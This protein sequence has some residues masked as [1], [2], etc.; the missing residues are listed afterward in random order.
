MSQKIFSLSHS[1]YYDDYDPAN[2]YA[3]VLFRP[4]YPVQARELTTLQTTIQDQLSRLG[5]SLYKDGARVSRGA[6]TISKDATRMYLTGSTNSSY[7]TGNALSTA[8]YAPIASFVNKV[9]SSEDG[10]VKARLILQP[11]SVNTALYIGNIYIKY[12]T[13]K[14]FD[15]DGGYIYAFADDNP[16]LTSALFNTYSSTSECTIASI[17]EGTYFLKGIFASVSEQ[18]LVIDSAGTTPTGNIGLNVS[19]TI[20]TQ[21]DDD[22]LFDNARGTTNEGSPGAHRLKLTSTLTFRDVDAAADS[23]FYRLATITDGV[24]TDLAQAGDA[25]AGA[26]TDTLARRTYDES[27]HYA[28]KPFTHHISEA[29]SDGKIAINVGASKAYVKG[30]EINKIAT[31]EVTFD[32][33]LDES[34]NYNF[35]VPF[36]GTTAAEVSAFTGFTENEI[37]TFK[38]GSTEVGRARGYSYAAPYLYY[39]DYVQLNSSLS[40]TSVTNG[41]GTWTATISATINSNSDLMVTLDHTIKSLKASSSVN[42]DLDYTVVDDTDPAGTRK[43]DA[44]A[45]KK[46]LKFAY[47]TYAQRTTQAYGWGAQDADLTLFFPDIHEVYGI[48]ESKDATS[49][50]GRFKRIGITTTGLIEPGTILTGDESGAVAICALSNTVSSGLPTY[51]STI[52]PENGTGSSSLLEIIYLT[53]TDFTVGESLIA[54]NI[55]GSSSTPPTDIVVDVVEGNGYD[56]TGN[57]ITANYLLDDGQRQEFYDIGRLYRTTNVAPKHSV[58]VFFSYFDV[59]DYTDSTLTGDYYSADS[60]GDMDFFDVDP[61]YY[62]DLRTIKAKQKDDG[63]DLRNTIDFRLRVQPTTDTSEVALDFDVRSFYTQGKILPGSTFTT[64]FTEYLGRIDMLTLTKDGEFKTVRGVPSLTPKRPVEN[65]EAMTLSFI[66]IPPAVRYPHDEVFVEIKD[67]RRYTMRDIGALDARITN[68]ESAVA[69][70]MLETQALLDDVDTRT[71]SGFVTDDFA[72]DFDSVSSSGDRSHPEFRA[73]TD[74]LNKYLI[75]AQTPGTPIPM[76]VASKSGVSTFFDN[77]LMNSFT[78][79]ALLSQSQ[80]TKTLKINPFATW[81]FRGE[82]QMT[83]NE[84]AWNIRTDGY[85]ADLYGKLKPFSSDGQQMQSFS[86]INTPTAAGR[87]L[88][89]YEWTGVETRTAIGAHSSP[90]SLKARVFEVGELFSETGSGSVKG[91]KRTT[92]TAVFDSPRSNGQKPTDTTTGLK[93]VENH[94]DYWMRSVDVVFKAKGLRPNTSHKYYFGNTLLGSGLTTDINGAVSG[95]FTIPAMSHKVG[96]EVFRI[97][98]ESTGKLSTAT[99]TFRSAGHSDP[100]GESQL[101]VGQTTNSELKDSIVNKIDFSDPIAQIFTLPTTGSN[102]ET[103]RNSAILTSID[104]WFGAVDTRSSMNTII[105]EVREVIGGFPG[106]PFSVIGTTGV[107]YLTSSNAV[108]APLSTNSVNFKFREPVILNSN[109]EYAV[110]IK[111][112]SDKTTLFVAEVGQKLTD[113]SGVHSSQSLVGGQLGSLFVSHS[114]S[115]WEPEQNLD[116]SFKLNYALFSTSSTGTVTFKNILSNT[117]TFNGDIGAYNQTLAME[118]YANSEYVKVYHPNHGLHFSGAK[119]RIAGPTATTSYNGILGSYLTG[120][121]DVLYPTLDSYFIKAGDHADVSGKIS[122]EAFDTF[123]TQCIAY[124]SLLTNFMIRKQDGDGVTMSLRTTK[125]NSLDMDV[126]TSPGYISYTGVA[127]PSTGTSFS[128]PVDA[129]VEFQDP[130]I[131]RN[132][133]NAKTTNDLQYVLK[134]T[135]G[136]T[137]SSPIIKLGTNTYPLVFRNVVG[138]GLSS[139]D[140]V[141]NLTTTSLTDSDDATKQKYMSYIQGVQSTLE[142]SAY[143]TKQIDLE[144]PADGITIKFTA[145]MEPSSVVEAS[146]KIKAIGSTQSFQ[147]IEWEDFPTNQQINETNYGPFTSATDLKPYTMRL[148]S[149]TEFTSFKVRLRLRTQNEAQIPHITDLRIIAD[150]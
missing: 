144:I 69:L 45:I 105:I 60:Y 83:P 91:A 136:T 23:N 6:L 48:N 15:S 62:G 54:K 49:A 8:T 7:T 97:V 36:V 101:I 130:Q 139:S 147:D 138:Y 56:A 81:E 113:G 88:T 31:T 99:A 12:L 2:D 44:A 86:Q 96:T 11:S 123:A 42:Y 68:V 40:A 65:E 121:F 95:T 84:D 117:E 128:A 100:I 9:I 33:G 53:G 29:D 82:I 145:D 32:N 58:V 77:Y 72:V 135:S 59:E 67:N 80:A 27:G 103:V 43:D 127:V 52:S 126:S 98:D 37:L 14:T 57:N 71:K 73:S 149:S 112:P 13:G 1:P 41:N 21:D 79:T 122:T 39:F 3:R 107:Q 34:I 102:G 143:V 116:L 78:E 63:R 93:V 90:K 92:S 118:T 140:V 25:L 22:S 119:V 55:N 4:S 16:D 132:A 111:T 148:Q 51:A 106:S 108:D 17:A 150:L 137:T 142:H 89:Q 19:E 35:H 114:S 10:S 131:V 109:K 24:I 110:V 134:F 104:L 85:F 5:E 70:N 141:T 87:S 46:Y 47:F 125:T 61:R 120:D 74:I 124:D 76:S 26:I 64:D 129:V 38:N 133:L 28:L 115:F 66:S 75:P 30:Y 18:N 94:Q 50:N 146:Y 20:V